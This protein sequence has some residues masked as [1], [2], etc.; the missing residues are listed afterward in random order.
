[1]NK[2]SCD[3]IRDLLP[4]YSDGIAS[5]DSVKLVEK[6]LAECTEC[7]NYKNRMA[8]TDFVIIDKD[9]N[10]DYM[11]KIRKLTD[12]KSAVCFFFVVVTAVIYSEYTKELHQPKMFFL[13]VAIMLLFNYVLFFNNNTKKTVGKANAI[14]ANIISVAITVYIMLLLQITI[15]NWINGRSAPFHIAYKDLGPF[16]NCQ[17][18]AAMI[19]EVIIWLHELILHIKK[20]RFSIVTS[21]FGIIGF[22]MSLYYSQMLKRV[23]TLDGFL[24]LCKNALLIFAEGI[25]IVFIILIIERIKN[26]KN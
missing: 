1:M 22:Y 18:I 16:I 23:E 17:L 5:D 14:I 8:K 19:I 26:A 4:S 20:S 2:I 13:L 6:H 25:A 9:I 21:S 10:L 15:Y 11:K 24:V 12:L 7:M 3:V